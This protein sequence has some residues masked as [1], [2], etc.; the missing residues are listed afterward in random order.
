M[1]FVIMLVFSIFTVE[2]TTTERPLQ[3]GLA[4][5]GGALEVG[6]HHCVQFFH[7]AQS[8]L[9][10]RHDPLLLSEGREWNFQT[11]SEVSLGAGRFVAE[12]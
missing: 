8:S 7:H 3:N 10:F 6:R 11:V 4:E 5:A 12:W 1:V 9:H 2:Q